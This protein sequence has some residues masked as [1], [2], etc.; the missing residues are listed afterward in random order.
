MRV[1]EL[2]VALLFAK[3]CSL[4]VGTGDL[5]IQRLDGEACEQDAECVGS[6]NRGAC[7]GAE[8]SCETL[9]LS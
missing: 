2:L 6:C 4:A 8:S 3:G 9:A 1:S 5:E 7:C